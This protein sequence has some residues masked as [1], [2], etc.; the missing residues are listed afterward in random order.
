MRTSCL[1]HDRCFRLH[2]SRPM[3]GLLPGQTDHVGID[4]SVALHQQQLR[5]LAPW[6]RELA[7]LASLRPALQQLL[8]PSASPEP[9]RP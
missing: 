7:S 9:A 1:I 4:A 2:D 6:I 3:P 8:Q 5:L